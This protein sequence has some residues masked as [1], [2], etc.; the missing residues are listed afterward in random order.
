M[1]LVINSLR[2]GD[3]HTH[4]QGHRHRGQKQFQE[5]RHALA[6]G[7]R[8]PGLINYCFTINY[9]YKLNYWKL[10]YCK[11]NIIITINYYT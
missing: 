5:T 3:T 2:G 1:P 8:A 11:L 6:E 7:W 4:T 10:N 9:Y